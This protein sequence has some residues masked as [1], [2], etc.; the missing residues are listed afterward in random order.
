MSTPPKPHSHSSSTENGSA[1]TWTVLELLRWTTGYFEKKGVEAP[2]AGAEL[3][4]AHCLRLGRLDLYLRYDQPLNAE[5]LAAFK[6]LIQRRVRGEPV[7]YIVGGRAFWT[8][9][10]K[11]NPE[12]LIP[13]PETE[14][15]VEIA[16]NALKTAKRPHP[17]VLDLGTGSGAIALALASEF[18]QGYFLAL[19]CSLGAVRTAR[20]NQHRNAITAKIDYLVA[21]WCAP[22]GPQKGRFD[23]IVSN[24]PYIVAGEIDALQTEVSRFEPRIALD[25]GPDGLDCLRQIFDQAAKQLVP[26]GTLI[27]EIGADQGKAVSHLAA[28]QKGFGSFEIHKDYAGLDRVAQL[29]RYRSASS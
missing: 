11:V 8:L 7:A 6:A 1:G 15:L 19:D 20:E 5:E 26:G 13:R 16:L 23:L 2:R 29:C 3:L 18:P 9:D 25:G 14:R 28:S 21:D 12:V 24:P 4:L 27:L 22:L 17:R 10:L